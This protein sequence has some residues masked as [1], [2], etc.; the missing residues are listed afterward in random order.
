M[1]ERENPLEKLLNRVE[2][3]VEESREAARAR[4]VE[5]E[6]DRDELW[7]EAVERERL[8][9]QEIEREEDRSEPGKEP[10]REHKAVFIFHSEDTERTLEELSR[11]QARIVGVVKGHGSYYGDTGVKGSWITFEESDQGDYR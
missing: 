6:A 7:A 8:L 11:K 10:E 2:E 3:N 1:S 4:H 5:A 9:A